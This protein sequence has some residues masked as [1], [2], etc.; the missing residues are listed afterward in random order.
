MTTPALYIDVLDNVRY[1]ASYAWWL[2]GSFVYENT[3]TDGALCDWVIDIRPESTSHPIREDGTR[4]PGAWYHRRLNLSFQAKTREIRFRDGAYEVRW[5]G[6]PLPAMVS[7]HLAG[8]DLAWILD[9]PGSSFPYGLEARAITSALG[10][11]KNKRYD[12]GATLLE[13]GETAG[14]IADAVDTVITPGFKGLCSV[15][16]TDNE[17]AADWFMRLTAGELKSAQR[18]K[19]GPRVRNHA[20]EIFGRKAEALM[21]ASISA[22]LAWQFAVKPLLFDIDDARAALGE[23]LNGEKPVPMRL[24]VRSGCTDHRIETFKHFAGVFSPGWD[25]TVKMLHLWRCKVAATYE[26]EPTSNTR[27]QQWGLMNTPQALYEATP[28]SWMLDYLTNTGEWLESLTP[29]E[30][31]SFIE[32]TITRYQQSSPMGS[33]TFTGNGAT[34]HSGFEPEPWVLDGMRIERSLIPPHGL[35]P[36]VRPAYRNKLNLER[37]A[38]VLA[39]LASVASKSTS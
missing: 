28:F 14:F 32:G 18:K 27:W 17:T 12:F 37:L 4:A 26:V 33:A 11:L 21:K 15:L 36:A 30:G 39:A 9:A 8:S 25:I 6:S 35:L 13:L 7:G 22:Y 29:V 3:W 38:N 24:T 31:A 2:D 10:K 16:P 20:N 34:L 23:V 19:Y 5:S 1:N